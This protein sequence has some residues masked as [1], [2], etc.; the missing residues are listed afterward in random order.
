MPFLSPHHD[1]G[2]FDHLL[3]IVDSVGFYEFI[4]VCCTDC[5]KC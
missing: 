5:V 2:I 3:L 1:C 4:D